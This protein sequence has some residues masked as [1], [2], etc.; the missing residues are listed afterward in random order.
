MR[1]MR[2]EVGKKTAKKRDNF[3]AIWP[4]H[5]FYLHIRWSLI[6]FNFSRSYAVK[7]SVGRVTHISYFSFRYLIYLFSLK[8]KSDA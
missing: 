6:N 7:C 1:E 3:A 4:C 2:G 8:D 5:K